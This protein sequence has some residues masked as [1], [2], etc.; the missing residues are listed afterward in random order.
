[1]I[2]HVADTLEGDAPEAPGV[3]A[4]FDG[5]RDGLVTDDARMEAG[6]AVCDALYAH[7]GGTTRG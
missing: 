6:F 7:C 1:V 5:I 4:V 2:V 3:A